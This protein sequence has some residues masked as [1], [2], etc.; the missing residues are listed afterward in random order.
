MEGI[1]WYMTE[2]SGTAILTKPGER[3]PFIKFDGAKSRPTVLMAA[4]IMLE[5][6]KLVH[7]H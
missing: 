2:V 7:L 3:R 4:I 5:V 1:E 6:T